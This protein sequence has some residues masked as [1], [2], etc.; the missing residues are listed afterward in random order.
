MPCSKG[1]HRQLG[2]KEA[3]VNRGSHANRSANT[4]EPV[5]RNDL[6]ERFA[7]KDHASESERIKERN[8][9]L[10]HEEADTDEHPTAEIEAHFKKSINRSEREGREYAS[11][12]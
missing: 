3:R 6:L 5:I 7:L 8:A 2:E 9:A 1:S 10:Q 11:S 12:D 4:I